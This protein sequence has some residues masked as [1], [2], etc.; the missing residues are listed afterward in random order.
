MYKIRIASI[1]DSSMLADIHNDPSN[2]HI[3]L[4]ST[5]D[6][7]YF[8]EVVKENDREIYVVEKSGV[9]VAFILIHLNKKEQTIFIDRFSIDKYYKKKGLDE[10]LYQ[11]VERLAKQKSVKQIVTSINVI[12]S[13][14]YDFFE[15]KGWNQ[16]DRK[17][18]YYLTLK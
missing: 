4:D 10:H 7:D 2:I 1:D 17:D 15:R 12:D 9:I 18:Q 6:K 16:A 13:Y 11:K 14:V 8:E 5:I 3:L